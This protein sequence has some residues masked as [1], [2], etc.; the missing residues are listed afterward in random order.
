M[1]TA[2]LK[3]IFFR[4]IDSLDKNRLEEFY[5]VFLNFFNGQADTVDWEKLTTE[6]K[7]GIDSALED[8]NAG[9]FIPHDKVMSE[10]QRKY[11]NA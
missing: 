7:Q 9:K 11:R 2:E 3:L 6:Q 8:I 10:I 1:T 5:G 4:Q